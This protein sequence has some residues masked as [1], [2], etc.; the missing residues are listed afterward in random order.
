MGIMNMSY[1]LIIYNYIYVS[2]H[3]YKL[4]ICAFCQIKISRAQVS[5][6]AS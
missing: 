4:F 5:F 6:A 3:E 2:Y 1:L